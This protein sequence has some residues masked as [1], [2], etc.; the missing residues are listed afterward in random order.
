MK[1]PPI[2]IY[3]VL[4]AISFFYGCKSNSVKFNSTKDDTIN[5]FRKNLSIKK[6]RV[7]SLRT[8][9]SA[10]ECISLLNNDGLF[11]DL[12]DK[13]DLILTDDWI[14]NISEKKQRDGGKF[15]TE[16]FNRLWR[17]AEKYRSK[18]I[19]VNNLTETQKKLF[20]GIAF[21]ANLEQRRPDTFGRFHSSCFAIPNAAVNIYFALVDAMDTIENDKNVHADLT[22]LNK[23]IKEIAMQ[24]WTKPKRDDETD[25]NIVSVS[26]FRNHVWWVGGNALAYRSLLP[27]AVMMKSTKMIDVLQE[28]AIKSLSSVSHNTY[29][30][31]FWNEGFTADGAGWG[32]GK[33]SLVWGYPIDGTYNA[34]K[35]LSKF[36]DTPWDA[37][38]SQ[39]NLAPIFNYLQGSSW[40]YYKGFEL[41]CLGRKSMVYR[42]KKQIIKSFLLVKSL[43]NNFKDDLTKEQIN[44][45]EDFQSDTKKFHITMNN[46]PE[47]QYSGSRWFFNNDDLVQKTENHSTIL[48]MASI[49]CDGSESALFHDRYNYFTNDGLTL[50]FRN[51]NEYQEA[52]GG[53][54]L[55]AIPGV[56]SRQGEEN[57]V[58]I[59]NWRGFISKH[60]FATAAT[61]GSK[62]AAA[63]FIFEK[64]NASAKEGV[65]DRVGLK[66]DTDFIYNV[67]AHK[68]YFF[69]GDYMLAL[70]SGITNN[71]PEVKGNIWTTIDQT[72]WNNT[73]SS[74]S[75]A[76]GEITLDDKSFS[77]ELSNT[78][79]NIIW[80]SQK[81]GFSYGILQNH[82]TGNV[83][84]QTEHRATKWQELNGLNKKRKDLPKNIDIFQLAINH[85]QNITN[86]TYGYL[87]YFGDEK[88]QQA[89]NNQTIKVLSNTTKLQ[90]AATKNK[91][92]I[93]A[94][95]Y[96][97]S[98][99][100][101][102]DA[103]W[104]ITTS[105]P[106]SLLLEKERN[107]YKITVTDAEM[108]KNLTSIKLKSTVEFKGNNVLK[109]GNWF[110]ITID[111]PKGELLGKPATVFLKL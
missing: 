49:R 72:L 85:G 66:F 20:K 69:L 43:L 89:F 67:K 15:L 106:S 22:L 76:T 11:I 21:Y 97:K 50:F 58:P 84:L 71:T 30:T 54:N 53:W 77:Q 31:A 51:G 94:V 61:S 62:N 47:K 111:L 101:V 19:D 90:A 29:D 14:Q 79:E 36:K 12:K 82:T 23:S 99:E 34:L 102:I 80:T 60:N 109:E 24:S 3:L 44:E 13:S 107:G 25:D 42:K 55:T 59:T 96:D 8:K 86:G 64:M 98:E 17:I 33:Q 57:L 70:G 26:R 83:V 10:D 52:M 74:N 88:P 81:G 65:N 27:A 87:V 5:E 108:N 95:F 35:L 68:S 41:P 4:F 91:E 39:E 110:T 105:A 7:K 9:K 37:N 103:N 104:K 100:L 18:N 92:I 28:V 40:Y 6:H 93:G 45:L 16:A 46:H 1:V 73:V 48:N 32:H 63:G 38:L 2:K 56:T 78:S 75:I